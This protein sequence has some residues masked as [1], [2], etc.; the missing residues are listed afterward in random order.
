[1][2]NEKLLLCVCVCVCVWWEKEREE[3]LICMNKRIHVVP[4]FFITKLIIC[5]FYMELEEA[6]LFL[7]Y[8]ITSYLGPQ[9]LYEEPLRKPSNPFIVT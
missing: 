9:S 2:M 3:Q 6:K 5:S 1:M 7:R 8:T 4:V